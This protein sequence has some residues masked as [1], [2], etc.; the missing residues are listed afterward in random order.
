M[1]TVLA[2]VVMSF[3][4]G[5]RGWAQSFDYERIDATCSA[6]APTFCPNG[7]AV[8]T[9]ANGINADGDIV[10]GFV[11]G[12]NFQ[13][14]FVRKGGQ[15]NTVDVPG[16]LVGLK[17]VVLPTS[18]NGINPAGEIVGNYTAPVNTSVTDIDSPAYCP[19]KSAACIKGFLFSHGAF[20][21]VLFAGHP[22]AIPQRI[23]PNGDIFGCLHDFDTG[24]SMFGAIWTRWRGLSLTAGGG[25][26]ADGSQSVPMSMNNGATPGAHM[27]VGL[28]NDMVGRH[29][30]I[31]QD[32]VFRSYDVP[33]PTVTL[34]AIWDLNPR[35][36][37]V[38]TYVDATGR[39]GF[40]QNPDGSDPIQLD[41]NGGTNAVANG[42]NP[43]GVIVGTFAIGKL[44]H[45]FVAVP[46]SGD[47]QWAPR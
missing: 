20:Y 19:S 4:L 27:I 8:Q 24:M 40:L 22:G 21:P 14:G 46:V 2:V 18:A 32:G 31:V 42:I 35:G 38:G 6:A 28:W 12:V 16:D 47:R 15:Y 34:T 39:H 37:F 45:G 26:L 30:F 29:G 3:C 1:R 44:S 11:D 9:S 33:S 41:V 43:E 25:E 7:V 5:G 17:G 10:G 36:Q 23:L 13:H